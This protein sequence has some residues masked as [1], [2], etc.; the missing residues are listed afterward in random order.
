MGLLD[1]PKLTFDSYLHPL[2][3]IC[4]IKKEEKYIS[5]H[6]FTGLFTFFKKFK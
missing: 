1:L 2:L 6:V 5:G 4:F 3:D